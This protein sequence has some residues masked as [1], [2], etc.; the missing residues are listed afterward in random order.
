MDRTGGCQI[1]MMGQDHCW[2][3]S[4]L[5]LE[6][7]SAKTK[8]KEGSARAWP[9]AAPMPKSDYFLR[10]RREMQND[11]VLA[12]NFLLTFHHGDGYLFITY[13]VPNLRA[14]RIL[15]HWIKYFLPLS[16]E[17]LKGKRLPKIIPFPIQ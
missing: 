17:I 1:V 7:P 8:K 14:A 10:E 4:R 12:F 13:L 5:R 11:G 16:N 3:I 2:S 9:V 6:H 15:S